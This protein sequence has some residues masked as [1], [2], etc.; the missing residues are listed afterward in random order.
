MVEIC[1]FELLFYYYL[2]CRYNLHMYI[3]QKL[4]SKYMI[5]KPKRLSFASVAQGQFYGRLYTTKLLNPKLLRKENR[6]F[7]DKFEDETDL[8]SILL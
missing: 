2:T 3:V 8:D 6:A 1:R 5:S 4:T 7:I